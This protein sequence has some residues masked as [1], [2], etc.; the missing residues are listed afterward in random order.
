MVS[1][2]ANASKFGIAR[3]ATQ[4]I[5]RAS[6]TMTKPKARQNLGVTIAYGSEEHDNLLFGL[7]YKLE[8]I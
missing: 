4:N 2:N 3:E 1:R 8:G 6:K 7:R 5:R